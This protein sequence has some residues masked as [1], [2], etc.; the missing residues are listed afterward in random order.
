MQEVLV[1]YVSAENKAMKIRS[2]EIQ[3]RCFISKILWEKI[4]AEERK[5]GN[6]L[7][8]LEECSILAVKGHWP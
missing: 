6:F 1:Y 5:F 4:E 7:K 3:K 8:S 2:L